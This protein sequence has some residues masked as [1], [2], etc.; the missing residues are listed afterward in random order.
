VYRPSD[1]RVETYAG[2]VT[3]QSVAAWKSRAIFSVDDIRGAALIVVC[4][5]LTLEQNWTDRQTDRETPNL[6]FTLTAMDVAA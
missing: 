1:R 5:A 3:L 4:I 6:C 2:R